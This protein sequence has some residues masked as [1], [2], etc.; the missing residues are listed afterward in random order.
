M[1]SLQDIG[2]VD[3]ILPFILI[4]TIVFAVLEKTKILG[5]DE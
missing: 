5:E 3:V 4:F 2:V 1:Y